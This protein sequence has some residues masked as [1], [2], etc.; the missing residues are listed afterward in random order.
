MHDR[1]LAA[2]FVFAI[3][4]LS[5]GVVL[6][7]V[8][9]G[10]STFRFSV[11]AF[12]VLA[13][14]GFGGVVWSSGLETAGAAYVAFGSALAIWGWHE[15]TFL[16]GIITGPRKIACPP[17]ARGWQRFG[18]GTAAVIHHEVALAST[19]LVIAA[20]TWG[21]PNQIGTS[22]FLVLWVM[23]LSAKLNVFLG[24][25]NLTEQFVPEHM[26][27]LLSYF[28]RARMN[29]LMPVSLVVASAVAIRLGCESLSNDAT[30][31]VSVGRTL[32]ATILTLA[33]VE[34][35]FLSLPL[36]DALLWR[37]AIRSPRASSSDVPERLRNFRVEA[38]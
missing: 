2:L 36:P 7:M 23:R 31:F 18:Y 19:L 12:S 15:L 1:A 32:V 8:W 22:T 35:V 16:L 6:K 17:E 25:R 24:V 11:A 13:L 10:R 21:K 14:A 29:W 38:P 28:R 9:L 4:W 20:A 5:T 30:R 37:W 3:W 27:Y 26:R 33:V 34:H